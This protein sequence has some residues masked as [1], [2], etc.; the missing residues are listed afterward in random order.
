M[1]AASRAEWALRERVK[2]LTC[3]YGIARAT[4]DSDRPLGAVLLQIAD[5][6]PPAWQ[7][8]EVAT[9]RVLLDGNVH[10]S[11][12]FREGPSCQRADVVVFGETRGAVEVFYTEPRPEWDEGPFLKEERSLIQEAA[13]QV[14]LVVQR[15]E[16]EREKTR[17]EEQLR[18]AD[19]LALVGQLAAGVAHELNEPLLAILGYAEIVRG[20]FGLPDQSSAE[21]GHIIQAA[22]RAR[23]IVRKLLVFAREEPFEKRP[24]RLDDV[25]RDALTMLG[26]RCVRA[27]VKP[28]L[29][30]GEDLPAVL[31]DRG[32]LEQV[33]V[34][35]CVNALQAMP[36]GGSLTL[37]IVGCDSEVSLSVRDS[38]EGMNEEVQRRL[39]TPF[40]T[41]KDLGRGTGLGLSVVHG[42][43]TAHGGSVSVDSAPGAGTEITV[44]LPAAL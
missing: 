10:A 35:L 43:V 41:T 2:E 3:L 40:F 27:G 24:V 18:R 23:E 21:L 1:E 8:R 31:G 42:I 16:A 15:R 37:T 11:R 26:A 6:L 28:L 22:L 44:L 5:L 39:F 30:V 17:L 34:N 13:R 38:G 14:G 7:Y 25:A 32:Q 12:A 19:R 4:D 36:E 33:I 9:A 29:R 20:S